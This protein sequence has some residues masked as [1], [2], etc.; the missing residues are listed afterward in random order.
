MDMGSHCIDLLEMFF[1]PVRGVSCFI[2]SNIHAYA[3]EDS[4]PQRERRQQI[5]AARLAWAMNA[6][7]TC[8][9]AATVW[10]PVTRRSLVPRLQYSKLSQVNSSRS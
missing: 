6:S 10:S 9:C 2:K 5:V 8:W 4:A 1:G 3:S 7:C